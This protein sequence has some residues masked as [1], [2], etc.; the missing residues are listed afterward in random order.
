M[1]VLD[2]AKDDGGQVVGADGPARLA[3]TVAATPKVSERAR[4]F[5]VVRDVE[6]AAMGAWERVAGS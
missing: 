6:E 1:T 2:D 5:K 3:L 4:Q